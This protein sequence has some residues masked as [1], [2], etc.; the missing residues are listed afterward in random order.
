MA[1]PETNRTLSLRIQLKDLATA[2][3]NVVRRGL[4]QLG[5]APAAALRGLGRLLTSVRGQ[6]LGLVAAYAGF[7]GIAFVRQ[8]GESADALIK[9]AESTG[10]AVENLS[11]LQAAAKLSGL[12]DFTTA[13]RSLAKEQA[14]ALNGNLAVV[15]S[16][17]AIGITLRDIQTLGPSQLFEKMADGL[18]KIEDANQRQF[19]LAKVANEQ[20]LELLPL[21]GRGGDAFRKAVRDARDAGATVTRS[22][23][24]IAERLNDAFT[25]VQFAAEGVARA[26]IEQAGPEVIVVLEGLAKSIASNRVLI[27]DVITALGSGIAQAVNLALDAIVGLVRAIESIPGVNL[28]DDAQTERLA[29]V[30]REL[31]Q[32]RDF[33]GQRQLLGGETPKQQ[34]ELKAR[35]ERELAEIEANIERGLAG[36]MRAARD[37]MREQMAAAV[38]EIRASAATRTPDDTARALGLP[39]ASDVEDYSDAIVGGLLKDI[40][41]A[42]AQQAPTSVFRP[43]TGRPLGVPDDAASEELSLA[44]TREKLGIYERLAKLSPQVDSLRIAVANLDAEAQKLDLADAYE[45]GIISMEEF[46]QATKRVTAELEKQ[47]RLVGG[48]D[49]FGGFSSG[50]TQGIREWT[51]FGRAGEEAGRLLIK[52]ALDG[53]TDALAA[54][55]QGTKSA[56]DA[57]KDLARSILAD[58]AKIVAKLI[59][60]QLFEYLLGYE[61]GGVSPGP[62]Q[63]TR[64]V[65]NF[66]RG[67]VVSRPTMAVFGEGRNREAFVPLPDNRS[68]PV[69]LTGG[70]GTNLTF[71]ITA[72]DG[73]DVKRVLIQEQATLRAV[74]QNQVETRHGMR[75]VLQRATG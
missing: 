63:E 49:F 4:E 44:R 69:T 48:G 28:V 73:Q 19:A 43:P 61:A 5:K 15:K 34:A 22:E 39:T 12:P 71:N 45:K 26:I 10:D 32:L 65:R 36:A 51:D 29:A 50:I 53:T 7:R 57:F 52:S 46:E 64:P 6:V 72:M 74:W 56:K 68:I 17:A 67:G 75:Q 3:L 25:K 30:R 60:L 31:K 62:I 14:K 58:I 23:A 1:S 55:I 38:A 70:G 37:S 2:P 13:I 41:K 47:K 35:L 9:L 24:Q 8:A 16:F 54:V 21:V 18:G 11:E 33:A 40:R 20:F 27:A 42:A 59:T 66:A